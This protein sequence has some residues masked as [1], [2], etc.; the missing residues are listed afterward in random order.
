M[1]SLSSGLPQNVSLKIILSVELKKIGFKFLFS[2]SHSYII[3]FLCL[4]VILEFLDCCL[5]RF[6]Y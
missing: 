3:C 5:K 2:C 4:K 1:Y 6:A